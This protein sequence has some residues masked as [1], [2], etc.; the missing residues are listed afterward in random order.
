MWVSV[1]PYLW[2]RCLVA[3]FQMIKHNHFNWDIPYDTSQ[4]S[5]DFL[6]KLGTELKQVPC[7]C[8]SLGILDIY[9][10]FLCYHCFISRVTQQMY[11]DELIAMFV[12]IYSLSVMNKQNNFPSLFLASI[13]ITVI[14]LAK[15]W[16]P[17]F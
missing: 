17:F 13:I 3:N 1:Y 7:N 14:L 8:A 16:K 12:K 4:V 5:F 10:N 2:Y 15:T 6:I 11:I 9:W